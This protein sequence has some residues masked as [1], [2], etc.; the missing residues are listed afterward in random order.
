MNRYMMTLLASLSVVAA[1]VAQTSAHNDTIN[2][3]VLVESTYNP[4]VAG[5]MKRNFIPEES[6]PSMKSEAIVYADE[7]I[8]VFRF[9]RIPQHAEGVQP[10]SDKVWPG[11]VHLGYGS[12]NN[13]N[14]LTAYQWAINNRHQ[15]AF[16][17]RID[18]WSGNIRRDDDT[19]WRSHLYDMGLGAR[20]SLKLGKAA[21][22]ADVSAARYAFNYFTGGA[23]DASLG[24]ADTQLSGKL[25]AGIHL[26][27]SLKEH[28]YYRVQSSYTGYSRQYRWGNADKHG[29]DHLHVEAMF[30]VDLYEW[31]MP[32]VTLRGDWMA[33]QGL[34]DYHNYLSLG[35][36]PQWN[37]GY[38]DFDFVVGTN[39]DFMTHVGSAVQVSPNLKATYTPG[40]I[41]SVDLLVDGGR[42]L[43]TFGALHGM[44]PYWATAQQLT[45]SYTFLNAALAG[46]VRVME[47]LHVRLGGGFKMVDNALFQVLSDSVGIVYTGIVNHD[48]RVAFADAR[49]DYTYKDL[50]SISAEGTF[51]HWMV[52]ADRAVLARAPRLDANVSA[53]VRIIPG[54]FAHTGCRVVEFTGNEERAII[55]WSLGARYAMNNRLS[56]FLDGHNLLNRRYQHYTGYPSQGLNVLVGAVC[57]F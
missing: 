45:P 44:S 5:A 11:Y 19:R 3:M 9:E 4:I 34:S 53:R 54:L 33:Y 55:N 24:F 10:Y 6:E 27:G 47:G 17:A 48:A 49:V 16:D 51:N 41:F 42:S 18:G 29:E 36:T 43:P 22:D 1:G 25:S 14:G 57:K 37:Y 50:W 38:G 13:L 52:S 7:S 8:P 32:S 46:N 15:L 40:S 28:Y 20:Y 23:Y 2:R 30:G 39:L 35:I 56:F 31:G 12:H 21:L 26:R